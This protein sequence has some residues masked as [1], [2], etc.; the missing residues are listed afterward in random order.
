[1]TNDKNHNVMKERSVSA[2]VIRRIKYPS[3]VG[4]QNIDVDFTASFDVLHSH[5]VVV[6]SAI[7]STSITLLDCQLDKLSL[8]A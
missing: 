6:F 8:A 2:F 5:R 4:L 7:N 1:M 3:G